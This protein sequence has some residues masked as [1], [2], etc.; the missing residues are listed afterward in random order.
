MNA[1]QRSSERLT[2]AIKEVEAAVATSSTVA[3]LRLSAMRLAVAASQYRNEA[4]RSE[5]AALNAA[6]NTAANSWSLVSPTAW[7]FWKR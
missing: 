3:Q 1:Q 7:R 6:Q 2:A 4:L 5:N